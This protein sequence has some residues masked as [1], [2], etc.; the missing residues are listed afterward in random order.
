M[1]A[2]VIEADA[3]I[4]I[5]VA[6]AKLDVVVRGDEREPHH[7]FANS[8][9]GFQQ[10][11]DW[12][13]QLGVKRPHVCLEAT[14]SYSDAVSRFLFE[15][16]IT[17]SVM[18]TDVLA[19]YRESQ[20]IH[21][22]TDKMDAKLLARYAA[23]HHPRPWKPLPAEIQTVRYLVARRDDLLKMRQQERNRLEAGRLD[24][25]IA[26]GVQEH[27]QSLNTQLAACELR[28]LTHLKQHEPLK[29]IWRRLQTIKGIGPLSAAALIAQIGE[30]ERFG[31]PGALV[32]LAG[33]AVKERR[34]GSS[35]RGRPMIDR[36]GRR[37]LRDWLYMSAIVSMR[38]DPHMKAWAA[39]LSA[40]GKPKKVVIVAVMRKLLHI[41]Y[42][43]WKHDADYDAHLAF[44]QAA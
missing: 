5:D 8:E 37:D 30:I 11:R 29:K 3:F 36:H 31:Q 7:L 40:R 10:M 18:S 12:W 24:E 34:S 39:Q 1:T 32:S 42:G 33:L 21:T 26:S 27:I 22:K 43:V 2:Q 6:K 15:Q 38:W 41:I 9:Q 20:Q 17:V 28:L 16:G 23:Q 19:K 25:W 35:V 4:G 44:P 13:E 14:G